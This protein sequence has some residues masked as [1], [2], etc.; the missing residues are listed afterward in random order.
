MV[1]FIIRKSKISVLF[2]YFTLL[3]LARLEVTRLV[4]RIVNLN[5][6]TDQFVRFDLLFIPCHMCEI[7]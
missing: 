1:S 5:Q 6:L 4:I 3:Q 7:P 2:A